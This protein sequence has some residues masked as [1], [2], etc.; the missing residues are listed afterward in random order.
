MHINAQKRSLRVISVLSIVYFIAFFLAWPLIEV[1]LLFIMS[2]SGTAFNFNNEMAWL[3]ILILPFCYLIFGAFSY[4]FVSLVTFMLDFLIRRFKKSDFKLA[5]RSE[6]FLLMGAYMFIGVVVVWL[7]Q[8]GIAPDPS[9]Y[10]PLPLIQL[11]ERN[12][13]LFIFAL[14]INYL[15]A[16]KTYTLINEDTTAS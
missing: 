5:T 8:T 3:L 11:P 1:G 14:A 9:T 13:Y 10:N 6:K 15:H 4:I 12:F 16:K 2:V 7:F